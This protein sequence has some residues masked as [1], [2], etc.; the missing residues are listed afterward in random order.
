VNWPATKTRSL[1]ASRGHHPWLSEMLSHKPTD[2]QLE[3][4]DRMVA[5]HRESLGLPS[6]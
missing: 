2:K 3:E 4:M 1:L 6:H 5:L